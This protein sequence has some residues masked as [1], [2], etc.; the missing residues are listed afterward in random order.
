M[1]L[2]DVASLSSASSL[3]TICV[4]SELCAASN[5]YLLISGLAQRE[6][7]LELLLR[8]LLDLLLLLVFL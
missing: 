1:S 6:F 8:V 4:D 3:S 5:N 7:I 2:Y